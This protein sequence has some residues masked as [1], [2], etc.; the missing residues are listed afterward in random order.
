MPYQEVAFEPGSRYSYSNPGFIY[1]A[2]VIEQ[3]S[4]DP[5][6]THVQK[7]QYQRIRD[8][9]MELIQ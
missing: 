5:W 4:G 9:A 2:R 7:N 1:L 3:L 6:E 8:Q